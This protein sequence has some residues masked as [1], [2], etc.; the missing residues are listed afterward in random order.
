VLQLTHIQGG[1]MQRSSLCIVSAV[2]ATALAAASPARAQW[3]P[4]GVPVCVATGNQTQPVVVADGSG[5]AY[6]V[7]EDSRGT[8]PQIYAQH[9]NA[10]GVPQWAPNGMLVSS[11]AWPQ[12]GPVAV[13]DGVGGVIVA[14][15][16]SL[17]PG[18]YEGRGQRLSGAGGAYWGAGGIPITPGVA[19]PTKLA[20]VSDGRLPDIFA[21]S[22]AILAWT[23]IRA[24]TTT[25][26]YVESISGAGALRWITPACTAAGNQSDV[27]IASDNSATI[28]GNP[29][30]AIVAWRDYRAGSLDPD[31][32]AQRINSTG[33]AVWTADGIDLA[34]GNLS[35]Q[36]PVIAAAGSQN[37]IVCWPGPIPGRSYGLFADRAGSLGSWGGP[38][39]LTDPLV[40]QSGAAVISDLAGG[41]IATFQQSAASFTWDLYAQRLDA[42]GTRSWGPTGKLVCLSSK[43]ETSSVIV[44]GRAG[45]SVIAWLD[46]RDESNGDVYAQLLDASGERQWLPEGVPVCRAA[47]IQ[48]NL[49][50]CPDTTG[51]AIVAWTDYRNGNA[52]VYAQRVTGH[53]SVTAV[54]GVAGLRLSVSAPWPSPSHGA[55]SLAFELPA[56]AAVSATVFDAAGR[57]VRTLLAAAPNGTGRHLVRWDGRNEAALRVPIGVYWI[58]LDAGAAHAARRAVIVR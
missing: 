2:L 33:A 48:T 54:E 27:C 39:A 58:A 50:A 44:Y 36:E 18:A 19:F 17:V 21:S 35:V 57:R 47:G 4:D 23:D 13:G 45:N 46:T 43:S 30:G 28:F 10:L 32:F 6:V 7:W 56:P 37:A 31:I 40:R 11:G 9:L 26:I 41:I 42:S 1:I 25:D 29:R 16:L 49:A 52:D 20:I 38:I 51:G 34:P 8:D 3:Q 5:G 24:G 12:Y 22:G 14:W 53:G 15:V 55:V